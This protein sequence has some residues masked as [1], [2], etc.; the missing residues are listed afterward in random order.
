MSNRMLKHLGVI[1]DKKLSWVWQLKYVFKKPTA[2]LP[3]IAALSRNT[4]EYSSEARKMMLVGTISA[5]MNYTS[6][7][8]ECKT[9]RSDICDDNTELWKAKFVVHTLIWV[10]YWVCHASLPSLPLKLLHIYSD[11]DLDK[12]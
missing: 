5:Y 1:L 12:F 9:D 7:E 11:W 6:A 8:E 10:V 2:A 3:K 4:F